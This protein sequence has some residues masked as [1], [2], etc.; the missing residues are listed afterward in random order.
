MHPPLAPPD[1][2]EAV[3]LRAEDEFDPVMLVQAVARFAKGLRRLLKPGRMGEVGAGQKVDSLDPG[4]P[5]MVSKRSS[6]LVPRAYEEC[7]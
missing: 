1:L 3:D 5:R 2:S 4:P 6:L 7:R